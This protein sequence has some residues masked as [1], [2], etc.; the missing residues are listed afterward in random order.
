MESHAARMGSMTNIYKILVG[1]R[2]WED[3]LEEVCVDGMIILEW[4][5]GK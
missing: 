5:L 3:D 1:K 2:E 4:I